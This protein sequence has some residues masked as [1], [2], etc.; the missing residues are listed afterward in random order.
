M[1]KDV[2]IRKTAVEG[3]GMPD[4]RA[5]GKRQNWIVPQ[6]SDLETL[7]HSDEKQDESAT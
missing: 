4:K 7:N 2:I 3:P 5:S 1:I 6:S